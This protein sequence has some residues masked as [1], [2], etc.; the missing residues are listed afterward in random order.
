MKSSIQ[1]RKERDPIVLGT[2]D[3]SPGLSLEERAFFQ[4]RLGLFGLVGSLLSVCFYVVVNGLQALGQGQG[5]L[6]NLLDVGNLSTIA[7]ALILALMWGVTRGTTKSSRVLRVVEVVG[8]LGVAV[9]CS[10]H[11]WWGQAGG[12]LRYNAILALT[13]ILIFRAILIPSRVARTLGLGALM[14]LPIVGPAWIFW[15]R[16]SAPHAVTNPVLDLALFSAWG[17]VAATISTVVTHV[18]YGLRKRMREAQRLGQYKLEQFLGAGGMG[19]VYLASHAMLRR[20]TAIKLLRPDCTS[21]AALARFEQE[22]QLTSQLTHPNTVAIFDFGRT[23]EGV[24][25]YAMEYLPGMTL[26]ALVKQH[27]PLP[28]GRAINILRQVCGS[29]GEAHEADLVHRDVKAANVILG[30]R[31]GEVDVAKVL[32][33]GLVR[34]LG[35]DAEDELP[36]GFITG[37]PAYIAPEAL[38]TPDEADARVDIYAVGVL[39]YWLVC[40]RTPFSGRSPEEVLRAHVQELP[41]PPSRHAPAPLSAD[42][43]RIILGCLHK[44]PDQRPASARALAQALLACA[45]AC[46]RYPQ[47]A[48]AWWRDHAPAD[49]EGLEEETD[50]GLAATSELEG[51]ATLVEP[52][53]SLAGRRIG[54]LPTNNQE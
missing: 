9:G 3:L 38:L 53:H 41:E 6:A 2:T 25:Y 48:T 24:F 42:L 26:Q 45:E 20:P 11:G 7:V 29:L 10:V 31:G 19:E 32:D 16:G 33:F 18:V 22:V 47:Y 36:A 28:P 5:V 8:L 23:P 54:R 30:A 17:F 39:A 49:G 44:K 40:G 27:G 34:Q 35:Q 50:L 1:P 14:M 21:A 4:G 51:P 43:E 12:A 15:L 13:N 52:G 46:P 37:T